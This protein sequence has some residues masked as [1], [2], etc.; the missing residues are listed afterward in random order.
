MG[1]GLMQFSG[2]WSICEDGVFRPLC[3]A[4]ALASDGSWIPIDFLID[5]GA[6]RTTL[7]AA[8]AGQLG[9]SPVGS[10]DYLTGLGGTTPSVQIQAS[11]RFRADDGQM[12]RFAGQF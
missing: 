5:T 8:D 1:S 2:T 10:R 4:L 12:L 3:R 11:I 7:M 6:D 9:L